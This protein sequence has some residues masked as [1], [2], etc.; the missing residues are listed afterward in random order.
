[1][2]YSPATVS[3]VCAVSKLCP[4]GQRRL[5]FHTCAHTRTR[6]FASRTTLFIAY[7]ITY[8]RTGDV[9]TTMSDVVNRA[10]AAVDG[11]V[12]TK[13]ALNDM[14]Y[15]SHSSFR[16]VRRSTKQRPMSSDVS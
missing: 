3:V 2:N 5:E 10:S 15:G 11:F 8:I 12:P 7:N 16:D 1:M 6:T 14:S 4:F 9:T 13:A